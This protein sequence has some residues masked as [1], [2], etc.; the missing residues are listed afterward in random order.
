ML[1]S[2]HGASAAAATVETPPQ[3]TRSATETGVVTERRRTERRRTE[4]RRTERRRTERRRTE[5]AVDA[6][7]AAAPPWLL[8][9]LLVV[10][11]LAVATIVVDE[12]GQPK[13]E[14]LFDGLMAWDAK[15]YA[16]I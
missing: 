3:P 5:R 4:R 9:R 7:T 10:A 6:L 1:S 15:L 2:M 13:P 14:Q 8:S 12:L 16:Q 11:S